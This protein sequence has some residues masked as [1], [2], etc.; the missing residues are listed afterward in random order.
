GVYN[1]EAV[2]NS[3]PTKSTHQVQLVQNGSC[4]QTIH[5]GSTRGHCVSSVLHSVVSI[6]QNDELAVTCDSSLG[7]TSYLS[8]VFMWG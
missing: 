7:D 6:A 4:I 2:V 8:A 5:C 1:V 3:T